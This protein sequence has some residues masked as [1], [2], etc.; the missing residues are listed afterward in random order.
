MGRRSVLIG[1]LFALAL[2]CPST[3]SEP[4][5]M[6]GTGGAAAD[7]DPD[8]GAGG[9]SDTEPAEVAL[10]PSV[11]P[12]DPPACP[13][14]DDCEDDGGPFSLVHEAPA[15]IELR[16]AAGSRV[17]AYDSEAQA[18][19]VYE[20]R[21][22]ESVQPSPFVLHESLRF[23][24]RYDRLLLD[25]SYTALACDGGSCEF[26]EAYGEFSAVHVPDELHAAAIARECVAGTGIACL[27]EQTKAWKWKLTSGAL[28][29]PIVAF[30]HLGGEAFVASDG[31]G[32][33]F[34][35]DKGQATPLDVG[36]SDPVVSFSTGWKGK[37]QWWVGR[38]STDRLVVGSYKGGQLCEDDV[39]FATIPY[40]GVLIVRSAETL[41]SGYTYCQRSAV[42]PGMS[43]VGVT[44]CGLPLIPYVFDAHHVYAAPFT[45]AYD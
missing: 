16:A 36:T 25:P 3:V 39:Q 31:Q 12:A 5:L 1:A 21:P 40:N 20:A 8:A 4:K 19:V 15:N 41:I 29:H 18:F 44:N 7:E 9:G 38:T 35:V 6:N 42:P 30:A 23:D 33:V 24:P 13:K 45:C 17:L 28:E 22:D 10:V 34:V 14:L 37:L 26:G 11:V 27:E 32:K 43:G 2:G